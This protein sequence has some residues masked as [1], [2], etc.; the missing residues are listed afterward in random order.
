MSLKQNDVLK[1]HLKELQEEN[2]KK[3]FFPFMS[4]KEMAEAMMP[5]RVG[6]DE[7]VRKM[8]EGGLGNVCGR[9]NPFSNPLANDP[10][11]EKNI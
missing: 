1:E 4:Q 2:D 9:N 8:M 7:K 3:E 6:V 11:Y 5:D 10:K